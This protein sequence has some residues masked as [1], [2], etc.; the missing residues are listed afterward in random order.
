MTAPFLH[1]AVRREITRV[2]T[3]MGH[4]YN[5]KGSAELRA[6]I[7]VQCESSGG[8]S[9]TLPPGLHQVERVAGTPRHNK[10]ARSLLY[11]PS[12][13]LVFMPYTPLAPRRWNSSKF[14]RWRRGLSVLP[15]S[16]PYQIALRLAR[17][18]ASFEQDGCCTH[19]EGLSFLS[20]P[21]LSCLS[22]GRP[23]D[24][25]GVH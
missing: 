12:W 4:A 9:P 5:S 6:E 7:S 22:W 23:S 11:S 17:R 18:R 15:I 20:S 14:L 24:R 13:S 16:Y 25:A 2:T 3:N 10:L 21:Y 8:G 1:Q 19:G